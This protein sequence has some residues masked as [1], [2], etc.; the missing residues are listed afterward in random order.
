ME[1]E[2]RLRIEVCSPRKDTI[3]VVVYLF[4]GSSYRSKSSILCTTSVYYSGTN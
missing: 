2:I 1:E 4:W 3:F